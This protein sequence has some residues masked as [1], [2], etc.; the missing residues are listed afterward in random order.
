LSH[1]DV[2]LP[3]MMRDAAG[4]FVARLGDSADAIRLPAPSLPPCSASLQWYNT[5]FAGPEFRRAHIEVFEVPGQFAVLH[6]CILP[7]LDSHAPIFGFDMV[8]GQSQAT[9][10]FL[11]YSPVT[12]AAAEMAL[13]D[14]VPACARSHFL[15]KRERPDWGGIF[16]HEFFAIRP[17]SV[18]EVRDAMALALAAL[19][20]YLGKLK[21]SAGGAIPGVVAGQAAYA[22]GQ[23]M[24]PHTFRMLSRHVGGACARRFIEEVLFP[25]PGEKE[26]LLF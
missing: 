26:D 9:G 5:L 17:S 21:P 2:D 18:G 13:S 12:A 16:S 10:I 23:R 20:H 22:R 4:M 19:A 11:D 25:L 14:A 7:H 15:H 3:G 1:E 6:A 24:N 8:S